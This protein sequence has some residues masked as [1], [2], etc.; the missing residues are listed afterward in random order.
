ML[1]ETGNRTIYKKGF[2]PF[3]MPHKTAIIWDYSHGKFFIELLIGLLIDLKLK[4]FNAIATCNIRFT[5]KVN[6]P[7]S[8]IHNSKTYRFQSNS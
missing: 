8:I 4:V 6:R 2:I 5:P 3:K 7:V 1:K